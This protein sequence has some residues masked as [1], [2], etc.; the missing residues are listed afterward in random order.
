MS[1]NEPAVLQTAEYEAV[2]HAR[3]PD[4]PPNK[5][6]VDR[7][8][9]W[10]IIPVLA[11][12]G[13]F[14]TLPALIGAFF[15]F[16]NFAGYGDFEFIGFTN[17]VNIFKDPSVLQPYLFT[18]FL[19]VVCTVVVN[20]VGLAVALGLNAK[21]KWRTGV[22]GIF[23]IPMVMSAL[24]VAYIFNFLFSNSLPTIATNLGITPLATSILA[25]EKWAWLAIVVVTVWQAAPGT[26]IIY[27]AGL[28]AIPTEMYEAGALDGAGAWR[29]FRSLTLPLLLGYLFINIILGFKGFLGAYEIIVALTG[30]GPGTATI[31]VAMK[32]FSGFTGGD[33]AYQM[34]NAVIYFL[35]TLIISLMQLRII[36]RRGVAL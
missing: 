12:F 13:F 32:I 18:F 36:Q 26:I 19:A 6:K 31:S 20:V 17:Y 25:N 15:S 29:Q 34:A 35:I 24:I 21:I 14:I 3:Q 10:M 9:Y 7:A 23:F 30:G 16:T 28:Q 33:Y 27:L 1:A 2:E 11:V 5:D 4:A 8:Y 22:R